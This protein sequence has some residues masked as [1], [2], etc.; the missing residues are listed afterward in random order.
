MVEITPEDIALKV[1]LDQKN[2][3]KPPVAYKDVPIDYIDP[4]PKPITAQ[5]GLVEYFERI[6]RL[7]ADK[8]QRHFLEYLQAS[9][10]NRHI[11]PTWA[12][13][14]AQAQLGKTVALSQV[15]PAWCMGHN[16]LW[17]VTLAMYNVS[18][19][20]AHSA[21]VIQIMQSEMH[22][23]IFPNKDGWIPDIV[24]KEK[25]KT[26]ARKELND[27]QDSFNPVGLVSGMTGSGFD[28]LIIDDPY[29]QPADAFSATIFDNLERFWQYGVVPRLQSYSCIAAMFHRYAYDD[30]GGYLLNTGKFDYVRYSSIADG[31]YIHEET[32]QRFDDPL[33]REKGELISP[34]RFPL[35]YYDDKRLDTKVFMSMFQGRPSSE[36]GDFFKVNLI[37]TATD[38]EWASATLKARGWDHAATQGKGD[39]S[40]GGLMTILPDGTTIVADLFEAQLD[41][42]ARVAKQREIAEADGY[43][44]VVVIPQEL[45][46]SGKDVVFL[47]QQ[48]LQGFTV[49]PRRVTNV[50]PG[51]DAKQRRAH[52]FSVAVNSGKVKF[53][54]GAWND[55]LKRLMRQFGASSSGDDAIDAL[56]DAYSYL[57][58]EKQKGLVVQFKDVLRWDA[59]KYWTPEGKLSDRWTVYAGVKITPEANMPNTGVVVARAPD[60]TG[61][62]DTLFIL[63][64]YKVYSDDYE[65]LFTWLKDALTLL[66]ENPQTSV[67]WVHKDSEVFV[68]TIR[69]KLGFPVILFNDTATAGIAEMNWYA[70]RGALIGLIADPNQLDTPINAY[71]LA[72]VRQE[73]STWGYNDK[74]LPN[75]VGQVLDNVRMIAHRFHTSARPLTPMEKIVSVMPEMY[76]EEVVDSQTA[77]NKFLW[78]QKKMKEEMEKPQSMNPIDELRRLRG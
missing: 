13:F 49:V 17:R 10:E 48:E 46:A 37:G 27:A 74:G 35:S 43:E 57:Y 52:N 54:P 18:R 6:K 68:P 59:F 19:S 16:P 4:T 1:R 9:V 63:A 38:D 42:A 78:M 71:G 31:A 39:M 47:M 15:F 8:W 3:Y 41:S 32:G 72:G 30:F 11:K 50:A 51:S 44:T 62:V 7:R 45:A 36:E 66:C 29:K 77:V 12:E 70:Q 21:T 2:G 76:K 24:S 40:A 20:Q 75:G 23:A 22:K 56:S 73:A 28:Y 58:E 64:E 69:Q 65:A 61:L 5:I 25:W 26:N 53:L 67:T 14:H 60:S 33:G 34:E 55:R